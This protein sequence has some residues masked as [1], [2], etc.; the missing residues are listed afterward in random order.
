MGQE[1]KIRAAWSRGGQRGNYLL[2][3]A[4]VSQGGC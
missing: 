2:Q 1:E 4:G 3:I